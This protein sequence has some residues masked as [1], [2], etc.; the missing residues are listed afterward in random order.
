[1]VVLFDEVE[2]AHLDIS[3][4]L[5]Q[6]L[7]EGRLTDAFGRKVDFRNTIV[8]FTSNLGVREAM[9]SAPLGFGD[10]EDE[11]KSG[12]ARK[13]VMES[14][15]GFFRPEFLNRVDEVGVFEELDEADLVQIRDLEVSKLEKRVHGMELVIQIDDDA[16]LVLVSEGAT[17]DSGARGLRRVLE[18]HLQ[19]RIADL[20]LDGKLTC[21]GLVKVSLDENK[22]LKVVVEEKDTVRQTGQ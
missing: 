11:K 12:V 20:I 6:V 21:G 22:K 5:L 15:K 3:N 18:D 10:S 14:V 4:T 2:K 16:K 1:M 8:I 7:E 17:P 9:N 13:A 19:D